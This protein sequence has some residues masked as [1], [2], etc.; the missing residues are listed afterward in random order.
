[1]AGA[2]PPSAA[3]ARRRARDLSRALLDAA[4]SRAV[5]K[6]N[7]PAPLAAIAR[8]LNVTVT[9]EDRASPL[10]PDG[11]LCPLTSGQLDL[12]QVEARIWSTGSRRRFTIAH[13]LAHRA[14]ELYLHPR[15]TLNWDYRTWKT[16]LDLLASRLLLPDDL[17]LD[18]IRETPDRITLDW[19]QSTSSQLRVS[20]SCMVTRLADAVRELDLPLSTCILVLAN[21]VSAKRK[22]NYAPR[23]VSRCTPPTW[24]IPVN[25][26]V[27][28]LG[29]RALS[30]ALTAGRLY[31]SAVL[32]DTIEMW[33]IS[34]R[35]KRLVRRDFNYVIFKLDADAGHIML[36]TFEPP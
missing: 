22:T 8:H 35:R 3:D 16:F 13:E 36:A 21:G 12:F 30:E 23:I 19:I 17:L 2:T 31:S 4:K 25:K 9:I 26:R 29:M 24:F 18:A 10:F 5:Y 1:M 20:I 32:E 6:F 7:Q 15:E 11:A 33:S 28:S 34:E 27:S 14:A